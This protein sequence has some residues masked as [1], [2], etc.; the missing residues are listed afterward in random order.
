[1]RD[2]S[3]TLHWERKGGSLRSRRSGVGWSHDR[4]PRR[5]WQLWWWMTVLEARVLVRVLLLIAEMPILVHI[6][7]MV[8]WFL[9]GRWL[10]MGMQWRL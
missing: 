8:R 1:M 4:W 3:V 2:G 5:K 7:K 6:M 10:L 9:L